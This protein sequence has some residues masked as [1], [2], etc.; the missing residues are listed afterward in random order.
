MLVA[1]VVGAGPED[2]REAKRA[3]AR[4]ERV[5][6]NFQREWMAEEMAAVDRGD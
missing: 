4:L 6:R 1:V 3:A 2:G 5:G